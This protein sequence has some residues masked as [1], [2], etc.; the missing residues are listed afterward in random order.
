MNTK[1]PTIPR[2]RISARQLAS[3]MRRSRVDEVLTGM[4]NRMTNDPVLALAEKWRKELE[5]H[6]V[7]STEAPDVAT[8]IEELESILPQRDAE[9]DAA[10]RLAAL[11]EAASLVRKWY[12]RW[13]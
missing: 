5:D 2:T 10:T 8:C 6:I 4:E 1:R 3:G 12:T 9:R 13:P 7:K 11:E